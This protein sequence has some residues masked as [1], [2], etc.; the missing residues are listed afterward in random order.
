MSIKQQ[1]AEIES[2]ATAMNEMSH[3]VQDVA[4]NAADT[5]AATE[6]A[7]RDVTHGKTVV[8]DTINGINKLAVEVEHVSTAISKLAADSEQIGSVVH[9]IRSIADQTNLLALNAAIEAARAGEQGRGFAVVADEV[10]TLASRTQASTDE[11]QKMIQQLQ[12][13]A[14]TAVQAMEQ[15]QAITQASVQQANNANNSLGEI[16]QAVSRISDMSMQIATAS[17]E[18]SSVTDE[19]NRNISNING[20]A[21][22][23]ATASQETTNLTR[24][25]VQE[26]AALRTLVIQ[27]SAEH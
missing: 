1:L 6:Q 27:F 2:V 9:V 17:E 14:S 5:A 11:I 15:G 3:T 22:I 20:V 23:T 24:E 10:R 26:A 12:Q 25:L 16:T 13:G 19:I 8:T 7:D 18:Q 21:E 4:Q